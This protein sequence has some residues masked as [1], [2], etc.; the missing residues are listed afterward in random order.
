MPT[1]LKNVIR[2]EGGMPG[3]DVDAFLTLTLSDPSDSLAS[4]NALK[5]LFVPDNS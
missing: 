2:E 3:F 4:S 1:F 5:I